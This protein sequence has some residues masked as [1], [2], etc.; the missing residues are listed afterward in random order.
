MQGNVLSSLFLR[1]SR[2]HVARIEGLAACRLFLDLYSAYPRKEENWI[3]Y[4]KLFGL[5]YSMHD[6]LSLWHVSL[7]YNLVSLSLALVSG[8]PRAKTQFPFLKLRSNSL[9]IRRGM[10]HR[11]RLM[12][13]YSRPMRARLAW[14]GGNRLVTRVR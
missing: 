11:S 4:G 14:K 7:F 10:E 12:S 3:L 6:A 5:R 2:N 8:P 1:G 13:L 9:Q